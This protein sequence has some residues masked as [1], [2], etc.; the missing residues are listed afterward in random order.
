MN[1]LYILRWL[2]LAPIIAILAAGPTDCQPI[3]ATRH[4]AWAGVF[5]YFP[6]RLRDDVHGYIAT[7]DCAEMGRLYDILIDGERYRVVV[8][9]CRN[10]SL[11][12]RTSPPQIDLDERIWWAANLPNR[13]ATVTLCTPGG[14]YDRSSRFD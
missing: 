13:P 3:T 2:L 1:G 7:D 4:E 12:K 5:E 11:P 8:A 6:D 14:A 9:D 10:R